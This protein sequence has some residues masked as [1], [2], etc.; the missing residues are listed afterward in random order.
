M[1]IEATILARFKRLV[2]WDKEPTLTEGEL[3]EIL[4]TYL[5]VDAN[6][7]LP[8]DGDEDYV[9]TYKIDLAAAEAWDVK[10]ARA[11]E[12]ISTD[13]DGDRMSSDQVFAHCERMARKYRRRTASSV[14][15]GTELTDQADLESNFVD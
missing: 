14:T 8:S 6:G 1:P 2:A 7:V 9:P 3:E 4:E 12:L 5:C 15:I 11:T 10:A 13:L